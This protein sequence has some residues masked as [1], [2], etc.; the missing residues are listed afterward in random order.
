MV[1]KVD[2][3]GLD[4]A[5][6]LLSLFNAAKSKEL[7]IDRYKYNLPEKKAPTVDNARETLLAYGTNI[8]KIGQRSIHVDL[9]GDSFN[10]HT[11]DMDNS[12]TAKASLVVEGIRKSGES[13]LGPTKFN[14]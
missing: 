14:F 11:Y 9:S 5:V 3:T 1:N 12:G 8:K 7:N 6:V 2:I 4:K 13:F 10:P